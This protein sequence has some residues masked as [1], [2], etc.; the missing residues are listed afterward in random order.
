MNN[1]IKQHYVPV[2]YLK[3]FSNKKKKEYFTYCYDINLNRSYPANIRNIGEEKYFY[4]IGNQNFE[5]DFKRVEDL[6]APIIHT[7]SFEKTKPLDNIKIRGQLSI[8]MAIQFLRTNE[9][10]KTMLEQNS[11]ISNYLENF[12]L[13]EDMEKISKI[14]NE[15]YIK[16]H[17][18][19]II[20]DLTQ[21]LTHELFFKKWILLK[22]KT[23]TPFW[24]SDNP[25]VRYNPHG[26]IGF[27]CSHIHIF[28]PIN[29]K[30]C[31]CLVD[32]AKY[33]NFE[34]KEEFS[35]EK[36]IYNIRRASSFKLKK[37]KKIKFINNL[38]AKFATK[39]LFSKN[40]DYERIPE[41]IEKGIINPN[42]KK[43][44]VKMEI[45]KNSKNN[46]DILHFYHPN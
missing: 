25:I 37:D 40:D 44:R 39:H 30:L 9:M 5:E 26:K 3:K 6:A 46:N 18:I 34:E 33:S 31:L 32:P 2:F 20:H 35:E 22:N 42:I 28:Y 19:G 43:E 27:G 1:T 4:K 36:A 13:T 24:T 15:Q 14:L 45:I 38:Q 7:L 8:F 41:L 12:E 21:N 29:P 23:Q 11:K 17:Q 10:R 16:H